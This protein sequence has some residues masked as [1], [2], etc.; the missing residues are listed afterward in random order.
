MQDNYGIDWDGPI[1]EEL[2]EGVVVPNITCPISN[3]DKEYLRQVYTEEIIIAS[4]SHAVD[5]F[6]NIRDYVY[7]HQILV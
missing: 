1:P 6:M 3:E 2:D 7:D 5:I 4:D